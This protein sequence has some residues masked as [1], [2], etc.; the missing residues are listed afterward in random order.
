LDGR[1]SR[2]L[3]APLPPEVVADTDADSAELLRG[4]AES[5]ARTV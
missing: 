5:K 1:V 4:V 3:V 2:P